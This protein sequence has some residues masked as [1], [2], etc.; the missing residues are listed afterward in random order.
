MYR[1]SLRITEELIPKLIKDLNDI[2]EDPLCA[3]DLAKL[4]HSRGL[5]MRHIGKVVAEAQLNHTREF[6][7]IEVISRC[8]KLLIRDGLGVLAETRATID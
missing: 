3:R 5:C 4:F 8:A 1:A 7:V 6:L 2:D